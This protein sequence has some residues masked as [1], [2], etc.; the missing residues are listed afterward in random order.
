MVSR[1]S[2]PSCFAAMAG[3]FPFLLLAA[4]LLSPATSHSQPGMSKEWENYL[5]QLVARNYPVWFD[6]HLDET[7]EID[8]APAKETVL[9]QL[10]HPNTINRRPSLMDYRIRIR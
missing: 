4:C 9:R 10:N 7:L 8:H 6:N 2:I 3:T 5:E 1:T